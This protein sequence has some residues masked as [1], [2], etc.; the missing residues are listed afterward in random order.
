MILSIVNAI[1]NGV[2]TSMS[3]YL[4]SEVEQGSYPL[5]CFHA[6]CCKVKMIYYRLS[7]TYAYIYK[8]Y[9]KLKTYRLWRLVHELK[10]SCM[11][12]SSLFPATLLQSKRSIKLKKKRLNLIKEISEIW[13]VYRS[14]KSVSFPSSGEI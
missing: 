14:N 2:L 8:F 7:K 13:K 5:T 11:C 1:E 6:R 12:P 3:C 4:A 10:L 9:N